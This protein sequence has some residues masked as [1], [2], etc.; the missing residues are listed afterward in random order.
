VLSKAVFLGALV[1]VQSSWMALFVHLIVRFPGDL[2][3]QLWLLTG[4]NAALTFVCLGISAT[5]RTPEQA[6]LV[7]VYL[8]GFQ[9]PL[10]GAVLALPETVRGLVR[11]FIAAYWSWAGYIRTLDETRLYEAILSVTKTSIS[12][13]PLCL[14]VLACHV[15]VGLYVAYAGCKR[16]QWD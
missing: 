16:A 14:W 13:V 1:L 15:A 2:A 6:S 11:P 12:S 3:T 7:S 9:L 5:L 4:V 8:V 10:S